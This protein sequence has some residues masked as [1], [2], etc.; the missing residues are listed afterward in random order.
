MGRD[1]TGTIDEGVAAVGLDVGQGLLGVEATAKDERVPS[2]I[3]SSRFAK[4]QAWNR[5]PPRGRPGPR[6]ADALEERR[7]LGP[8]SAYWSRVALGRRRSCR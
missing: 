7:G 6:A 2:A 5:A 1:I 8:A 4:P 3:P